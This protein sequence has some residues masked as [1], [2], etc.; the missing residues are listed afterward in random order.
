MMIA[1]MVVVVVV[2]LC[3]NCRQ[4]VSVVC[5]LFLQRNKAVPLNVL[6]A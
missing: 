1:V 4:R 3:R 5:M 2:V 6:Y